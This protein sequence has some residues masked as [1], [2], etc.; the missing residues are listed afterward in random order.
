MLVKAFI[1]TSIVNI[2]VGTID[3]ITPSFDNKGEEGTT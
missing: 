2:Y 3:P 1:L